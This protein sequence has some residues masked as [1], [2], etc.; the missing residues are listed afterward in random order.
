MKCFESF[1]STRKL[2]YYS[3][4]NN[5]V[6]FR[7]IIKYRSKVLLQNYERGKG[8]N[9]QGFH[10]IKLMENSSLRYCHS[11]ITAIM[12]LEFFFCETRQ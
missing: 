6:Y 5:L 1:E 2:L 3:E 12:Q 11:I 9:F 7:S 10:H 4:K 8:L